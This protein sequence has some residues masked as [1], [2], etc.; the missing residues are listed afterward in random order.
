[1]IEL[2]KMPRELIKKLA[3]KGIAESD[4]KIC[5]RSDMNADG[6]Y[7]D[8][9]LL[10]TVDDLIVIGGIK[11]VTP[12]KR[13]K[14]PYP[15]YG[16][17]AAVT[18]AENNRK[19]GPISAAKSLMRKYAEAKSRVI[20][21]FEQISYEY[22]PLANL[23]DFWIEEL[24]STCRLCAIQLDDENAKLEAE[25]VRKAR[26][27]TKERE[28]REKRRA[29]EIRRAIEEG[30]P[31]PEEEKEEPAAQGKASFEI[32]GE[33]ILITRFTN[34]CKADMRLFV[35]YVNRYHE[36]GELKFDAEDKK[37]ELFCPKCGQRYAN[38]ERKI[39]PHCMD[40]SK[41]IAR[42]A[43]FFAKYKVYIGASLLMLI[44][45]SAL[46]VIGPYVSSGFYYDQVLDKN[47]KYYGQLLLV[48]GIV[49]GT[50]LLSTLITMV[51]GWVSAYISAHVVYDLKKV[52]FGAIERLS[53]SFFTGRQTGGLMTQ[54]NRDANNIYWF[55]VDGLPYFTVN[56]VQGIVVILLMFIMDFWLTF[57]SVI[58]IPFMVMLIAW[59]FNRMEKLW[60][61]QYSRS[62]EL[63]SMLSDVLSGVRVVKAFSKEKREMARFKMHSEALAGADRD[64]RRFENIA[65]PATSFLL[66]IAN[67]VVWLVGGW[68]VIQGEMTYGT[69]LVFVSYMNMIWNPMYFFVDMV[70]WASSCM[71]AMHRLSE[72]MD[73]V[74]DVAER[75]NPVRMPSVQGRVTFRNV[76]FSYDKNRKVIDGVSFNIEPGQVIGIVGHT[77]AGKSTLANLLI[78]LYD[79]TEGEILIDGINVRDIAFDDLRRNVA[80]VSQE[81][82][83]FA[84]TILDNIRY[85]KPDA[86]YEEVIEASKIAGAH[87]FIMKMPDA[88]STRIGFGYKDLSGGERQRISIARAILRNPKIL[89]LDEATAA[90]DTET[91]RQIQ[92]ALAKLV[93]GRTTIMIAH[94]L[95]TLRDA[96]YLIVLENGKMPEFGTH[97]ELISKKGIY[98]RLYR[99]QLEALRSIGIAE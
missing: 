85:A 35:K 33:P 24:I 45:M 48:L 60:A 62:R 97:A 51:G 96:D 42:F 47:G 79:T 46:G 34:T 70:N 3:E 27:E 16:G 75:E 1:L 72:I 29:E 43:M 98:F 38:P 61:H 41:I 58:V 54:V 11:T 2:S 40:K 53:I 95:S 36:T 67:I 77:G 63:N 7:C 73:A 69:L 15:E 20:Y 65:F 32:K 10:V 87:S 59:L 25:R 88:Y 5:V 19:K 83:L 39:C 76:S 90:M 23:K 28:E 86:T 18:E 49:V 8:N 12:K 64:M 71:N 13:M 94:R 82:Y 91:E 84:G 22:Y 21:D 26:E 81:T 31:M 74:P 57:L 17:L 80:I 14:T 68:K 99:L 66:Y 92:A 56:I 6:V 4:I 52:I 55:F 89:I 93:V 78:R 9:W 44:V 37:E 50:R 30:R